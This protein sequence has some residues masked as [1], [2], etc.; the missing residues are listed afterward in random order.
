MKNGHR[1]KIFEEGQKYR[2]ATVRLY[3]LKD[4]DEDHAYLA[5]VLIGPSDTTS[6]FT[7]TCLKPCATEDRTII[8][9]T[10]YDISNVDILGSPPWYKVPRTPY[11][12]LLGERYTIQDRKF[13]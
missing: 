3:G 7:T 2:M 11:V 4:D 6:P 13:F 10:D 12:I 8:R 5:R 9:V 1:A